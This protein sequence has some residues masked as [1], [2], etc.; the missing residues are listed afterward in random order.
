MLSVLGVSS[1]F[2]GI[3]VFG[4]I[5]VSDATGMALAPGF[6]GCG[7]TGDDDGNCGSSVELLSG[8]CISSSL[9]A[10]GGLGG[11]WKGV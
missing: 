9:F 2:D 4:T 11:D 3:I 7:G 6:G 10:S 8:V 5:T 1:K